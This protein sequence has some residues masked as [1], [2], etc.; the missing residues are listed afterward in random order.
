M[1]IEEQIKFVAKNGFTNAQFTKEGM[2][3]GV[4]KLTVENN[5]MLKALINVTSRLY[6]E[7]PQNPNLDGK[8]EEFENVRKEFERAC[9]SMGKVAELVSTKAAFDFAVE[10]DSNLDDDGVLSVVFPS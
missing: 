8:E 10:H 1:T 9:V 6:A 4:F 2:L 3:L 5:A 7:M